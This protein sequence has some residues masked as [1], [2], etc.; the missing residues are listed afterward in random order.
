M[1]VCNV[2]V[3]SGVEWLRLLYNLSKILAF[4][5]G[6]EGSVGGANHDVWWDVGG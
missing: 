2:N 5:G 1:C 3:I 4:D 6:G